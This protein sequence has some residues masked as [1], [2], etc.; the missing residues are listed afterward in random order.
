MKTTIYDTPWIDV[1][2]V[3]VT[4]RTV[5]VILK[6]K[7]GIPHVWTWLDSGKV[8]DFKDRSKSMIRVFLS[9]RIVV[10][11]NGDVILCD[12]L[13]PIMESSNWRVE[14]GWG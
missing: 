10:K 11:K 5:G 8:I 4:S 6:A 3:V 12:N 2:D 14:E 1:G 9:Q 7:D 13:E